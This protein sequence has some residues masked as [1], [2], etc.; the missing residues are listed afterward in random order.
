MALQD[1]PRPTVAHLLSVMCVL[2]SLVGAAAQEGTVLAADD[3]GVKDQQDWR[4]VSGW[5]GRSL[6][7]GLW[8]GVHITVTELT[9]ESVEATVRPG[10][11]PGYGG[12]LTLCPVSFSRLPGGHR[13]GARGDQEGGKAS[14]RNGQ[15]PR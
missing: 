4:L 1:A 7:G 11:G 2:S 5:F 10:F 13:L 6:V 12:R 9:F 8:I 14:H 15:E 3:V